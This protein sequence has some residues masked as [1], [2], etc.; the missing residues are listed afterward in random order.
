VLAVL[1]VLAVLVGALKTYELITGSQYTE[2]PE[3]GRD[4]IRA[5]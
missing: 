3:G 4:Q 2:E 1:A 5:R